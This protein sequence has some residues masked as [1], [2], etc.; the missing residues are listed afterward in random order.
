MLRAFG[1]IFRRD[2]PSPKDSSEKQ[3]LD[4]VKD[5]CECV[6]FK[7][8]TVFPFDFFPDDLIVDSTKVNIIIRSFFAAE[9]IHSILIKNITHLSLEHSAFFATLHILP[10]RIFQNQVLSIKHLK[11]EEALKARNIIQ[12]LVVV[13][14]ENVTIE[15]ILHTQEWVKE[16]EAIGKAG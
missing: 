12:G 1:T 4:H 16:I 3:Q 5:K 2:T 11:K 7:T 10:G 14:R 9:E 13:D 15:N 8:R 6:L